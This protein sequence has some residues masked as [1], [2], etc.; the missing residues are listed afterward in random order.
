MQHL[1][2]EELI[3][4]H[5][6]DADASEHLRACA[7]CRAQYETLCRVLSLVDAMPVP[8]RAPD[9]ADHVWNR[10]RWRL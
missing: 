8:D 6:H 9:Y 10:L 2:D 5:Y 3:A 4:H 7:D 1:N